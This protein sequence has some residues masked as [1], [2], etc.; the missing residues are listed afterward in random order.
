[1]GTSSNARFKIHMAGPERPGSWFTPPSWFTLDDLCAAMPERERDRTRSAVIRWTQ[2]G[3]I[4]WRRGNVD[5]I[6][7]EAQFTVEDA[8]VVLVLAKDP[9][10][11]KDRRLAAKVEA[12]AR[13]MYRS[14]PD[15]RSSLRVGVAHGVYVEWGGG[16]GVEPRHALVHL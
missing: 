13:A 1:M 11:A 14:N 15:I 2:W 6:R 10:C 12:A 3:L 7:E 4:G 9:R 5:V 16:F 8:F